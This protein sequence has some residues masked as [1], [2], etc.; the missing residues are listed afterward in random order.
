MKV[1]EL[2]E[3]LQRI[4]P[5]L[6]I[7]ELSEGP[8]TYTDDVG[9]YEGEFLNK[10]GDKLIFEREIRKFVLIG[11]PGNLLNFDWDKYNIVDL[12]EDDE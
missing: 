6:E 5:E 4:D 9:I 1:K 10:Y 2:I 11:N 12:L 7:G 8:I 3:K